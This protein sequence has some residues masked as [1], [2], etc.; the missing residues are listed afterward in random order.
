MRF[1]ANDRPKDGKG[2]NGEEGKVV[3]STDL[4]DQYGF[5]GAE[6]NWINVMI[7]SFSAILQGI[8]FE[9]KEIELSLVPTPFEVPGQPSGSVTC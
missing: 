3:E 5:G 9:G 4:G 2:E 6:D 1:W 7:S 8:T